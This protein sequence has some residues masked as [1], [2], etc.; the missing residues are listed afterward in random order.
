MLQVN[1]IVASLLEYI[2]DFGKP[3]AASPAAIVACIPKT[4][5]QDTGEVTEFSLTGEEIIAV[6]S[7]SL[8]GPLSPEA[9]VQ[10]HY[11]FIF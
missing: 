4:I 5:H 1:I 8:D 9:E 6:L 2:S 3:Y 7:E 10:Y 11:E